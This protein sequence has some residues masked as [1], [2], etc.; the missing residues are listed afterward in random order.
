M[1]K[2]TE[3]IFPN[4][5]EP[6]NHWYEKSLNATIHPMVSYFL[7]L[8]TERIIKRY[9][10]LNPKVSSKD[11]ESILAYKPEHYHLSGADLL[12]VTTEKGNRQMVVI[13]NNSCPSGQKSMP[14]LNEYEESGGYGKFMELTIKPILKKRGNDAVAV[15]YDKNYMEASGY[16]HAM[17]DMLNKKVYLVPYY[18]DDKNEHVDVSGDS[19]QLKIDGE[20]LKLGLVFRYLTQKPW[21]RLP[22]YSKTKIVNPTI[23]CLAG[24]RNKMIASKAYSFYNAE[25]MEQNLKILTPHTIWDVNKNEIPLWVSKLGGKAVVKNPYSNAGQG[26]YTIVNQEEL[27]SFMQL[28]FD[29]DK[30]IVQSLVGNYNWSST[31]NEGKFYHVGTVPNQK[32]QSYVLDFRMMIHATPNGYRPLSIYSR[33][34]KAPLKDELENGKSSWDILGTNLSF[35]KENGDWGSDTNRLLVMER[36]E[37][38][39]LGIGLDD[40]IEA[41]I[42]TVLTSIAID[43]M[44][45][46]LLNKKGGFRRKLFKSLNDDELLIKEIL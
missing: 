23:V 34:A 43:K 6:E 8:K 31:T 27:D 39:N 24:G 16:A 14:L 36:K 30:F 12:H 37:F 42:Q 45:I 38:N 7:N 21:N 35:K 11:L 33:R 46:R 44:A 20:W 32:G 9:C 26:V 13:E 15:I 40:L 28:D 19:I 25:L 1:L 5:L 41:Y 17:A 18:H 10:H 4:T 22:I 3:I 29:Y 2:D